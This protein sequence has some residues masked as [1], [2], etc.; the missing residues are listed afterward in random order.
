M[1]V[2]TATRTV[3]PAAAPAAAHAQA[4]P[5]GAAPSAR[6][7]AVHSAGPL[8]RLP[9]VQTKLTVGRAGDRYE[10][11]ADRMSEHVNAGTRA[12]PVSRI[13]P[14][15]LGAQRD[16]EE[17]EE[18]DAEDNAD[19]EAA[20]TACAACDAEKTQ[21]KDEEP[22]QKQNDEAQ[23]KCAP[24]EAETPVQRKEEAEPQVA[25][26]QD[27]EA[28]AKCA[29]C[30]A[31]NAAQAQ[32][33]ST[34]LIQRDVD[35]ED[36]SPTE[37]EEPQPAEDTEDTDVPRHPDDADLEA[38][39]CSADG[40]GPAAPAAAPAA[41]DS[42]S[43]S[44]E[45]GEG[46]APPG[47]AESAPGADASLDCGANESEGGAEEPEVPAAPAPEGG[48]A[49][50]CGAPE[51]D[52]SGG[53]GEESADT[54]GEGGG[55]SSA[56][57]AI[58]GPPS[59]AE[60]VNENTPDPTEFNDAPA[61]AGA[62]GA[63]AAA[64][65]PSGNCAGAAQRKDAAPEDRSVLDRPISTVEERAGDPRRANKIVKAL[66]KESRLD[67][68]S[69]HINA[70]GTGEALPGGVRSRIEASM[71]VDLSG[72]RVHTDT[73]AQAASKALGAKAFTHQ[74]N[75]FIG[76]G[77]SPHDVGLMAHETTH[78]LQ[79][80]AIAR[81]PSES[82]KR[83][84][85]KAHEPPKAPAIAPPSAAE[86][87][88]KAGDKAPAAATSRMELAG[89]TGAK[90]GAA[91][92][93]AAEVAAP[94]PTTATKVA[95]ESSGAAAHA[96]P[97]AG[98]SLAPAN[99]PG[100]AAAASPTEMA[101]NPAAA[102]RAAEED[103]GPVDHSKK[104]DTPDAS[105]VA[106]VAPGLVADAEKHE[107][108]KHTAETVKPAS[109]PTSPASP[110]EG[111]SSEKSGGEKSAPAA[112]KEKSVE[113][114]KPE[115]AAKSAAESTPEA[116]APSPEADPRF[117]K[118]MKRL[119]K[120][121]AHERDHDPAGDKVTF[122]QQ[123][124]KPPEDEPRSKAQNE[125]VGHMAASVDTP[126]A[127]PEKS[128]EQVLNEKLEAIKPKNMEQT[129]EFKESGAA[130]TLREVVNA[131]MQKQKS[132]M[133]Q[134]LDK[135]T[136]AKLP[137]SDYAN[138]TNVP[139]LE[140]DAPEAAPRSLQAENVLPQPKSD[141]E[142]SVDKDTDEADRLMKENDLDEEQ[143]K[144]ANEP[145]FTAVIEAKQQLE[146]NSA[147]VV[148]TYR[149]HEAQQL[150][151]GAKEVAKASAQTL[152]AMRNKRKNA[153][154]TV[155]DAQS[156]AKKKE[157]ADR[158]F[159]VDEVNKKFGATKSAVETRLNELDVPVGI[160]FD[161]AEKRARHKFEDTVDTLMS[162]YKDDRY[163]GI[164]GK[165][166]WA[167]DKL[168]SMPSE[169]NEFYV[170][171]TKAYSDCM[172]CSFKEIG[173]F[174]DDQLALA[175][176]DIAKGKEDIQN[177]IGGLKGKQK[178]YGDTAFTAIEGDF[179][180]LE[181]S[182]EDKKQGLANDLTEKYKKS[183]EDL[184]ARIEELKAE[185]EGLLGKLVA[186]IKKVVAVLKKLKDLAVM[187]MKV[188][189]AVLR[190]IV[191]DPSGFLGNLVDAVKSGF[192]LFGEHIGKHLKDALIGFVTGSMKD[193]GVSASG[194]S[195]PGGVGGIILQVLG[196]TPDKLK[197][198]VALKLGIRDPSLLERAWT[199]VK[200]LLTEG[201][202]GLWNK[203]KESVGDIREKV[204]SEMKE[205]V[206][207]QIIKAGLKWI[208]S[209][210]SPVSALLRA[211]KMIYDVMSFFVNNLDR[212][213][214]LV[215]GVLK[216]INAVV[217]GN[218]A[219]AAKLIESAAAKGLS[220]L[221][222]F[223]ASLLGLSGVGAK[224]Q[225]IVQRVRGVVD[226]AVDRILNVMLKPFKWIARKAA[227][228]VAKGKAAVKK[229]GA[230]VKTVAKKAVR[231]LFPERTFT[232]DDE[233]HR[234]FF[235]GEN[236]SAEL[237]MAS[238]KAT[239]RAQV[240]QLRQKPENKSGAGKAA[241]DAVIKQQE[242]ID[243]AKKAVGTSPKK[244]KS[245][246]TSAQAIIANKLRQ[247]ILGGKFATKKSPL[248]IPW[249]KR[250]SSKYEK[251]YLGPRVPEDRRVRQNQDL[252]TAYNNTP[253]KQALFSELQD[254]ILK[255]GQ[256]D[257]ELVKWEAAGLPIIEYKPHG[258]KQIPGSTES[259]GIDSDW[260]VHVGR[261][262]QI[263]P[264]KP[265]KSPGGK[266]INSELRFFGYYAGLEGQDGDHVTEIQVGG[267]DDLKN[268]WPLDA[269]ENRSSGSTLADGKYE[270]GNATITM[271][272]LKAR[273]RKGANPP[274]VWIK[275]G[276]TK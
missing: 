40:E 242:R 155:F 63:P 273:A 215:N 162:N 225:S 96:A 260:Q 144:K 74:N 38:P 192:A 177:F 243:A 154:G 169:V 142:I 173:K 105:V 123:T 97:A 8:V 3:A 101:K 164:R 203:L 223:L 134:P 211:I 247:V 216:S 133:V 66:P 263:P 115:P 276:S 229:A 78:V 17:H 183:R 82:A 57:P 128:F 206:A 75:V 184:D 83:E 16:A 41:V 32:P 112:G 166:R 265:P 99:K 240:K 271:A 62:S 268:L 207:F 54:G 147:K 129:L 4:K 159:V 23:A 246:M 158:A 254:R 118:T 86:A 212:I 46:A 228:L 71:G 180:A 18:D 51:P 198:K 72:V 37:S 73:N 122:A 100:P 15:S 170:I 190:G 126:P 14:G 68:A 67:T 2:T 107:R 85:A 116:P 43:D 94:A 259:L 187:L 31:E 145:Q 1:A 235:E 110:T 189:G 130:S 120:A 245:I 195:G 25:Q 234:L 131:A 89:V 205:W 70:R 5:D 214:D 49:P 197:E 48:A 34:G 250:A 26:N 233:T 93:P 111:A 267:V 274:E 167:W 125:N 194:E 45:E 171:G 191:K 222:G 47:G 261:K 196:L 151:Q 36:D 256:S 33:S 22:A 109:S 249:P 50:S 27:D 199:K 58:A 181:S 201:A 10:R 19:D 132:S 226:R 124:V 224:M 24:C 20:Q 213:I 61:D 210:F 217:A 219:G 88:A 7:G 104:G 227:P 55:D 209:L 103:K 149:E 186:F 156:E 135:A 21:K 44:D 137:V 146:E 163:S 160:M 113:A 138:P 35:E 220:V 232:A 136:K 65:T 114:A 200:T 13:T 42:E 179:E 60:T 6:I 262:I 244:V 253:A 270:V 9:N 84:A 92:S 39:D 91:A 140:P 53:E 251:L 153:K 161:A 81:K 218:I 141:A 182:V 255:A 150:Q 174:V 152:G 204:E 202:S 188:G 168:T 248:A 172:K 64:P 238:K 106:P 193:V 272:D 11:E 28:Q 269:S 127:P 239:V 95:G 165:A 117:Q 237:M 148:P 241:L 79:Q 264:V 59:C 119:H 52:A 258:R 230:K 236:T 76:A 221:L 143:L 175:K 12:P 178:E 30:D 69:A 208:V 29:S 266:K 77:N 56:P 121:A 102:S 176:T 252:A 90:T 231:F 275:I 139:K 98:S 257:K 87:H 108:D 80:G 157:E 185:N